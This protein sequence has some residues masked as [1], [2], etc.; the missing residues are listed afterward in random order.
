MK[1]I[2]PLFLLLLLLTACGSGQ[3]QAEPPS[4]QKTNFQMDTV[5]TI[6]L[7]DWTDETAIDKAFREISRLEDL[8]SVEKEGSDLDR[9]AKAAGQDWVAIA[10]ETQEVLELAKE[11]Y[12][13]SGGLLDVTAGP[14]IDLWD[15]NNGGHYPTGEELDAVLPL[16]SGDDLLVEEGRAYLARPEMK[17]NLGA[18]AKGYIADRVKDLLV[19]LGV[20][21]AVLDLGRN[22]LLIGGKTDDTPFRIGVQDPNG[23][24]G[25]I[26]AV[27]ELTDQSLVTSGVYERYFEYEGV[28]YH[29]ILDPRTGMPSDSGLVQVTLVGQD[30]CMLDALATG[31]FILGIR[32][33]MPILEK[34]GCGAIFVT[35]QGDVLVSENLQEK[36]QLKKG[37][38]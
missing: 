18:I 30:A 4:V 14:L 37:A 20:E 5:V 11:Y 28:R 24:Q 7:F 27:L 17:A 12:A 8:L 9:L 6:T 25:A 10:P 1:R 36:F 22:I 31:I 32:K 13:V 2:L 29:H 23:D 26:L 15:I 34:T 33:G 3:S 19:E 38:S 35:S 21:H 16:I